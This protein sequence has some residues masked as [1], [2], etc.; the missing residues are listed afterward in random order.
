[1]TCTLQTHTRHFIMHQ[2]TK[3]GSGCHVGGMILRCDLDFQT[4]DH[5]SVERSNVAHLPGS[6]KVMFLWS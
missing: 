3:F 4:Y 2:T 1:M 6:A 5:N